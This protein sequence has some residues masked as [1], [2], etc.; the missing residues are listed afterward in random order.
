M[1]KK[2]S[3]GKDKEVGKKDCKVQKFAMGGVGKIR[4]EQSTKAGTPKAPKK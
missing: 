4:H 3:G 1:D 2:K